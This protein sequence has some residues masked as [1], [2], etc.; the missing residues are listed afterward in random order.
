MSEINKILITGCNGHLGLALTEKVGQY[1]TPIIIS[2]STSAQLKQL[3]K[4][5]KVTHL[6]LDLTK[7]DKLEK[8]RTM[9]SKIETII[10]LAAHVPKKKDQDQI[11]TSIENNLIATINLVQ[12]IPQNSH[13][14][15][16]ST[17]E[18]YGPP[19]QT[20]IT[21]EHPLNPTSLYG[22]S[23][24]AA[25]KYLQV[26]CQKKNI[27]LTIVRLT[28]IYGPGETI[29][30][31]IPNFI[32]N[33]LQNQQPIIYGT[34]E[35]QRDFMY[36]DD[37][38]NFII[39]TIKEQKIGVYNIVQGQ[40]ISI[41]KI[42][43]NICN[44][45]DKNITPLTQTSTNPKIDYIFNNE[46]IKKHFTYQPQTL[47]E[48]GLKKEIEWFQQRTTL[49]FDLDGTL[50][51]VHQRIYKAHQDALQHLNHRSPY[52]FEQY[53]QLK[54]QKT[55]EKEIT[56]K[57]L[58]ET[59]YEQ[60]SKKRNELI[61]KEEY[62][63]L[64]TITKTSVEKIKELKKDH[65][66]ILLTNRKNKENTLQQLDR[67]N[68]SHLFEEIIICN[69]TQTKYDNIQK[70]LFFNKDAIIIGDTEEEMT[71]GQKLGIKHIAI[72]SGMRTKEI[73]QQNQPTQIISK[74]SQ[75]YSSKISN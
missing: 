52:T 24:V 39:E 23:K 29:R 73:L 37:A 16:I 11:E 35:D 20:P 65:W 34:G 63:Q 33:A 68:L 74:I 8:Y 27:K 14:I 45:I 10:H 43:E 48:E 53:I 25:E 57:I 17:C 50:L 51:D 61:E 19:T 15:F 40:S 70:S 49:F 3:I 71:I 44:L 66:L 67:L 13:F 54:R 21:E 41:K 72:T 9:F 12:V 18:V 26:Y 64:D 62:L 58:S 75:F 7:K 46:K 55:S 38:I 4:E 69:E 6:N 59:E 56:S 42:A 47:L 36:I 1:T 2:K 32:L 60:Y 5:K 22:A 28:N 31:A 30:R